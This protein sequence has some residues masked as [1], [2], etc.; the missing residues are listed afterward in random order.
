MQGDFS[1]YR[2]LSKSYVAG[3]NNGSINKQTFMYDQKGFGLAQWTYFTRKGAMYDAWKKSG[4]AIDDITFQVDFALMELKQDFPYLF[5]FL[6]TTND[7]YQA[8]NEVCYKF[9][10]P[11]VKNVDARYRAANRIRYEIDLNWNKQEE[12]KT[13]PEPE[14]PVAPTLENPGW[15]IIPATEY[16]PPRTVDKNMKGK[17]I[18]VL[19]A[20]LAARE[21]PITTFDGEFGSY[22]ETVVKQF[23]QA[24]GLTVDGI[25]GKNTWRKLLEM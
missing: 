25:V 11:A 8:C 13:D 14:T 6:K 2:T 7:V 17:D 10:N 3:L 1:S 22:L 21:Y 19:Q 24:N 9:E 12:P 4:K 23:Q 5:Q 16:W 15:E 18:I 20:L